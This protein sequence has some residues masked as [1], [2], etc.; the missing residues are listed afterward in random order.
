MGIFN[1]ST[2]KKDEFVPLE[3]GKMKIYICGPTVYNFIR[4]G[5]ARPMIV[6]NM[7][8]RYSEYEGYE[9]SYV[10]DFTDVNDKVIKKAVEEGMGAETIF[11]RY[12]EECKKDMVGINVKPVI[13]HPLTTQEACGIPET[14]RKLTDSGHTYKTEDGAVYPRTGFSEEY[15]KLSHK[16][17]EGLQ[18]RF[19]ETRVIGE[20]GEEDLSDFVL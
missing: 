2:K 4:I 19:R 17:P 10:S 18:S 3:P 13:T 11:K 12:I 6:S 9:A 7:V 5:G 14:I 8:R 1:T 20:D 16:N 15:G